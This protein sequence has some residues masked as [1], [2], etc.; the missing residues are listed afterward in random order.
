MRIEEKKKTM[1]S[2]GSIDQL[3][4]TDLRTCVTIEGLV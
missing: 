1:F 3:A 2:I 4:E